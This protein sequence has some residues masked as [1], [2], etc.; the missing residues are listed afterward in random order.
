MGQNH[1]EEYI[2]PLLEH[3]V[4][5]EIDPS[6]VISHRATLE[7]APKM[8]RELSENRDICSRVVM[9]PS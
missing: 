7:S 2:R 1:I 5:G 3:I 9:R 8:Y 6:F 4:N